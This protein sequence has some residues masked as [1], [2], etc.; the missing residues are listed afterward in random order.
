MKIEKIAKIDEMVFVGNKGETLE[1]A[2]LSAYGVQKS[3]TRNNIAFNKGVDFELLNASIKLGNKATMCKVN[4]LDTLE[5]AID[6]YL[7]EDVATLYMVGLELIDNNDYVVLHLTK[8]EYKDLLMEY[9]VFDRA[10]TKNTRK[11]ATPARTLRLMMRTETKQ[12]K[13]MLDRA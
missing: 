4:Q 1:F 12:R 6:R 10:S 2:I 9:G 13:A 11:G 5:Q 3:Y 8:A 7:Q